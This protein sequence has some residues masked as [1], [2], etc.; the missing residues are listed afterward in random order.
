MTTLLEKNDKLVTVQNKF[1]KILKKN[2][3]NL[4]TRVLRQRVVRLS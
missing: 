4:P 3:T 2:S 1:S